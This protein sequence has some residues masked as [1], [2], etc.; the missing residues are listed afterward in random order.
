MSAAYYIARDILGLVLLASGAA[1]A[2]DL[3][4]SAVVVNQLGIRS[5]TFAQLIVSGVVVLEIGTGLLIYAGIWILATDL[6]VLA[7]FL[8]FLL[9]AVYG[10]RSK[11]QFECRCFGALSTTS[12]GRRT[13]AR[14]TGFVATAVAILGLHSG[15]VDSSRLN[16]WGGATMIIAMMFAIACATASRALDR[17]AD[18]RT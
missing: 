9:V 3:S 8:C 14:N 15:S 12:F 6:V 13:V 11:G 4:R 5:A 17:T 2:V 1:K 16:V 7:L 18:A 10:A